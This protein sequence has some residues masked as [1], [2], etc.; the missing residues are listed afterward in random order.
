MRELIY[1]KTDKNGT[2]YFY[3]WN[4]ARCGG[5]GASDKWL[6][7]GRTCYGC[8]G[9]G[10]RVKPKIIKEYTPEYFAKLQ[11]KRRARAEAKAQA[12][13]NDP[14]RQEF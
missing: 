9:T 7:T 5:A 3:D 2:K 6:H 12:E 1:F 10:E 11:D 8:G 4:C 14:E 13:A